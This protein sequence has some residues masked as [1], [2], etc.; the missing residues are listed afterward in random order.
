MGR[1]LLNKSVDRLQSV[2]QVDV[3]AHPWTSKFQRRQAALQTIGGGNGAEM[4]PPEEMRT[5]K[6]LEYPV[7]GLQ[8]LEWRSEATATLED[9]GDLT[10]VKP[11]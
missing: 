7:K 4:P 3:H 6:W 11:C 1:Q 10:P 2:L 5:E 8:H 9:Q